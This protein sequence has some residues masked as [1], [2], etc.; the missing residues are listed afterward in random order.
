MYTYQETIIPDRPFV[1][2]DGVLH[3][4]KD[5][6]ENWCIV[7][8]EIASLCTEEQLSEPAFVIVSVDPSWYQP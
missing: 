3:R 6:A 7:M 4:T 8:N 1:S 5:N 2:S